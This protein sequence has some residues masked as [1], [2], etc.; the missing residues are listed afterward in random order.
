M[1]DSTEDS[2]ACDRGG[3]CW[4]LVDRFAYVDLNGSRVAQCAVAAAGTFRFG[5][6]VSTGALVDA[7]L[8]V[9]TRFS[10]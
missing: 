9:T 6:I 7:F 8:G 10:T 1:I 3:E 5:L 4:S 2:L